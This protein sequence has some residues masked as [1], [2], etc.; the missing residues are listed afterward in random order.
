MFKITGIE[1][2]KRRI[3]ELDNR[4]LLIAFIDVLEKECKLTYDKGGIKT[5]LFFKN[6]EEA[7]NYCNNLQ[8][9]KNMIIV[10]DDIMEGGD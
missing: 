4:S 3:R 5:E 7:E 8:N 9:V 10:I 6:V 2:L 1:S